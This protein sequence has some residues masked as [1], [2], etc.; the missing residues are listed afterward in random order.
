MAIASALMAAAAGFGLGRWSNQTHHDSAPTAAS[1]TPRRSPASG[2]P[3]TQRQAA[4]NRA[5]FPTPV[6]AFAEPWLPQ[7]GDCTTA[8]NGGGPQLG[9]GEQSRTRC[10]AGIITTYWI[11]YRTSADRDRA[12]DRYQAQAA[13]TPRLAPGA[14]PPADQAVPHG[15]H[16]VRYIEYAYQVP[17]GQHAGQ[18][19]AALWW[20]DPTQPIAGI[21]LA[22]WAEGLDSSWAPLRDLWDQSG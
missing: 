5:H 19:V 17:S 6:A 15:S 7:I 20:S 2:G 21:L 10:A 9:A 8:P 18:V 12:Q 4:A 1:P 13:E 14:K 22:Y 16:T 11:S 3:F